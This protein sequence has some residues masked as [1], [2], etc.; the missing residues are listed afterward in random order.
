MNALPLNSINKTASDL[1]KE[2]RLV[3]PEILSQV[4]AVADSLQI[5]FGRV[6]VMHGHLGEGDLTSLLLAAS[7]IIRGELTFIDGCTL[8][9]EATSECLPFED[10]LGRFNVTR[11]KLSQLLLKSQIVSEKL[12][13]PLIKEAE[14]SGLTLGETLIEYQIITVDELKA[15]IETLTLVRGKCISEEVA[16]LALRSMHSWKCTLTEALTHFDVPLTLVTPRLGELL[17]T[18]GVLS[19]K[20]VLIA[21]EMGVESDTPIGEV[22]FRLGLLPPLVLK[23]ALRLQSMLLSGRLSFPQAQELLKQAVEHKLP[24]EQVLQELG[25]LKRQVLELLKQARVVN[26]TNL[27]HTLAIYESLTDEASRAMMLA[28]YVDMPTLRLAIRCVVLMRRNTITRQQAEHVFQH[29]R[30]S[31]ISVSEALRELTCVLPVLDDAKLAAR[32]KVARTA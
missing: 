20:Q 13:V 27:T 29:C 11:G 24:V 19:E 26:G 7:L 31:R 8:L 14:T 6:L 15:A 4:H 5:P 2:T 18:A 32:L 25:E 22:L 17:L 23:A 10:V 12:L 28:R 21:A 30:K 3:K 1:A 16:A 9:K